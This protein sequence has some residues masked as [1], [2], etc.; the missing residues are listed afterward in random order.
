MRMEAEWEPYVVSVL[1]G[2]QLPIPVE[3]YVRKDD[4]LYF[5]DFLTRFAMRFQGEELLKIAA[6]ARPFL[7]DIAEHLR[8]KAAAQRA[9]AVQTLG[10]LGFA[11]YSAEIVNALED[12]SPLVAML[13]ARALAHKDHPEFV[14]P[15]ILRLYRFSQWSPKFLASM[16]S[17]VGPK[18]APLLRAAYADQSNDSQVRAVAAETLRLLN[19]L[20]SGEIAATV[21][22]QEKE[23][24]NLAESVRRR[25]GA[26]ET[27]AA[28][29]GEA[30][31]E[32]PDP[33][34]VSSWSSLASS[35]AD[36]A[37]LEGEPHPHR[38]LIATSLRLVRNLGRQ[39]HAVKARLF[40]D[41]ADFV[42]RECAYRALG[43]IGNG[44]D[45]ARLQRA[46]EDSSVWVALHAA[47]ALRELG[48]DKKLRELASIVHPHSDVARQVLAE[49]IQ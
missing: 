39:E 24:E 4:R 25:P 48:A 1:N 15:V 31:S 26:D 34:A 13:A 10:L 32:W 43:R 35:S 33:A 23:S 5:V 37:P 17:A 27:R 3:E 42:I 38:D 2:E 30:R 28:A 45:I 18:A 49:S 19:D 40:C 44:E 14:A 22:D 29:M 21:L 7:E 47:R 6:L 36:R 9:R 11:R 41:S 12:E 16:L 8:S 46:L 20:P